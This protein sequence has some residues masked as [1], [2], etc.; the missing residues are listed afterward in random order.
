MN[1]LGQQGKAREEAIID[2]I[3]NFPKAIRYIQKTKN[4]KTSDNPIVVL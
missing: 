1:G 4:T 3:S 2:M